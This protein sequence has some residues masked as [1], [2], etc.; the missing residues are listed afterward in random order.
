MLK[1]KRNNT[2]AYLLICAVLLMIAVINFGCRSKK[3]IL[4][5]TEVKKTE[6]K[7]TE[8]ATSI[9]ETVKTTDSTTTTSKTLTEAKNTSKD[10]TEIEADSVVT[11]ERADGTKKTTIYIKP[12]TKIK[13]TSNKTSDQKIDNQVAT[14]YN[15]KGEQA[16]QLDSTSKKNELTTSDSSKV[17][18]DEKITGSKWDYTIPITIGAVVALGI[19]LYFF[20]NR[21]K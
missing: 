9:K 16:R 11:E 1:G 3:T 12:G 13:N 8:T 19:F 2:L 4:Q 21:K 6:Q 15:I 5:S 18:K 17:N 14:N 7:Q 20:F 10:S